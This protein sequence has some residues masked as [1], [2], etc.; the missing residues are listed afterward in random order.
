MD[1]VGFESKDLGLNLPQVHLIGPDWPHL[2]P[3]NCTQKALNDLMEPQLALGLIDL[4]LLPLVN[5]A[6]V[7]NLKTHWDHRLETNLI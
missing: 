1:Q 6:N 5:L 2:D 7:G 4:S 3:Y